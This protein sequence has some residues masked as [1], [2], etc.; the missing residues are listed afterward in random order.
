L[1]V[2]LVNVSKLNLPCRKMSLG[3]NSEREVSAKGVRLK[4][5]KTKPGAELPVAGDK[6]A[7]ANFSIF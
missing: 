3:S 6:V 2:I 4:S 1:R 7:L 5:P